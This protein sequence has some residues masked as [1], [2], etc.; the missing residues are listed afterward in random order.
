MYCGQ[1]ERKNINGSNNKSGSDSICI[2]YDMILAVRITAHTDTGERSYLLE[3]K[4]KTTK[5]NGQS[6]KKIKAT[7]TTMAAAVAMKTATTPTTICM[8]LSWFGSKR[9]ILCYV[10]VTAVT[11]AP[12]LFF[13]LQYINAI[14]T[15]THTLNQLSLAACSSVFAYLCCAAWHS[16]NRPGINS[17]LHNNANAVCMY[18]L[19]YCFQMPISICS[20]ALYADSIVIVQVLLCLDAICIIHIHTDRRWN[21]RIDVSK[22]TVCTYFVCVP[23]QIA[24]TLEIASGQC[25]RRERKTFNDY[26]SLHAE[27]AITGSLSHTHI[28]FG[29]SFVHLHAF[30]IV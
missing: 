4:T 1:K 3:K 7:T 12:F 19:A 2:R 30:F 13:F 26:L 9:H 15:C 5:Q 22:E 20:L 27:N 18:C 24:A 11:T 10:G 25:G 16:L 28:S 23:L 8:R 29:R 14:Y 21:V 17:Q 6:E